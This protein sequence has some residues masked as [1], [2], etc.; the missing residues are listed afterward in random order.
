[1]TPLSAAISAVASRNCVSARLTC[2]SSSSPAS[3]RAT[4]ECERSN[5]G[6]PTLASRSCSAMLAAGCD[7]PMPAAAV[8]MCLRSA[9]ANSSSSRRSC[10]A[11]VKN[12]APRKRKAEA[13]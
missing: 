10:T 11:S 4:P 6:T 13:G 9:K 5:S 12:G 1:M 8:L 7:T 2:T 3:V